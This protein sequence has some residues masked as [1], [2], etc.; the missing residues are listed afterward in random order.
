MVLISKYVI[1]DQQPLSPRDGAPGAE[2]LHGEERHNPS[3]NHWAIN[4]GELEV[5]EFLSGK[6]I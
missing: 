6:Q 5:S 4:A 3:K 2:E 1:S